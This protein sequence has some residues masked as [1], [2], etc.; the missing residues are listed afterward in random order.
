MII[1]CCCFYFERFIGVKSVFFVF[2]FLASIAVHAAVPFKIGIAGYTFNKKSLDESLKIMQKID[3]RYLCHKDFFLK[4]DASDAEIATYL[5]KTSEYG[6]KTLATGPLYAKDE[7]T[8][9][10]QFEFA[11]K[12]GV[13]ILVG[14]PYE[15]KRGAK[16]GWGPNRL[17]SEEMLDIIEK[18]VK[19]YDMYYAIH[20]HGPDIPNLYPTAESVMARISTRDRRIGVCLDVGHERRAG[21]DPVAFIRKHADRI[22]DVH[23]KNIKVDPVRNIAMEGPRGELDIPAIFQALA[24]VGYSGVCH[25]EYE[26]DFKDN[27]MGL[28]ESFGYYRGVADC[29]RSKIVMKPAPVGA[30]TLSDAEKSDGWK[31]LWDGKTLNGWVGVKNHFKTPPSKGW[32]VAD[33]T[34]TMRPV[35]GITPDGNWFPLPPEDQKLGGGGDIVTIAKYRDFA[36]KFDFRLTKYAN[37]GVKYFYDETQNKGTCEEYQILENGHPDSS[38]GKEGNRKTASLYDIFPANADDILKSPGEWNSGMIVAKG[39]KI[40]HWLNGVK[41]LE[42]NRASKEFKDGVNASKYASWGVSAAGKSQPWG[43]IP[44]GRILLQDHSDSTV[45]FCNLKIK[46]FK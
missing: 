2:L 30:N 17:E 22:F 40:E 39:S 27:A 7:A 33:G 42:Y 31:L 8:V 26:K 14:V 18:L 32:V 5:N 20:N 19:E 12:L 29:T 37:S 25:I 24:D 34:L 1:S 43:E 35:N 28:A 46:E 44:E 45:S 21:C 4:Y 9:R 23:I 36:F 11:K 3:C 16:D 13:K 15:V 6:V 10:A 38:K 41:V